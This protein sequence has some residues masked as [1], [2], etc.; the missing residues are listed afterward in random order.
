MVP[1]SQDYIYIRLT[2]NYKERERTPPADFGR[3][4]DLRVLSPPKGDTQIT[5]RR[6]VAQAAVHPFRVP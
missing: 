4:F 5:G 3:V 6:Q 1:N 2:S